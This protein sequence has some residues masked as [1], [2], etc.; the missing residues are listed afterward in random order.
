MTN[1]VQPIIRNTSRA[2]PDEG[3]FQRSIQ[4]L[5]S[6]LFVSGI[7]APVGAYS[8]SASGFYIRG[9]VKPFVQSD[10]CFNILRWSFLNEKEIL[11]CNV[12]V[13]GFGADVRLAGTGGSACTRSVHRR[14][15]LCRQRTGEQLH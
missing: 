3:I 10:F 12:L 4:A 2:V 7:F 15:A 1:L 5:Y 13:C 14:R 9:A 6:C 8:I 11:N